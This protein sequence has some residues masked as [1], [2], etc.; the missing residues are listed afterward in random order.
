MSKLVI[1]AVLLIAVTGAAALTGTETKGRRGSCVDGPT[2]GN[3]VTEEFV[4]WSGPMLV[5][6]ILAGLVVLALVFW[7]IRRAVRWLIV[8][9]AATAFAVAFAVYSA[10]IT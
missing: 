7:L 1:T 8:A 10:A 2:G 9:L 5:P 6:L 3:C 4:K